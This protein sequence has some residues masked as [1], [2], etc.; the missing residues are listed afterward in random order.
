MNNF[1]PA[2]CGA[3]KIGITFE[4]FCKRLIS[5]AARV[6]DKMQLTLDKHSVK[7]AV[8][9]GFPVRRQASAEMFDLLIKIE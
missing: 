2:S 9:P 5:Q 1:T 3:K 8:P 6:D 4:E 7:A